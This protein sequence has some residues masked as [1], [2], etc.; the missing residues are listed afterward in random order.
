MT[1]VDENPLFDDDDIIENL[2]PLI[3][4]ITRGID[5]LVNPR[6]Q[7]VGYM[8]I[9]IGKNENGATSCVFGSNV[10]NRG[11]ANIMTTVADGIKDKR[12]GGDEPLGLGDEE[13]AGHA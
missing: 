7:R 13:P 3:E 10:K 4:I 12:D 11:A 9:L 1:G 2:D 8:V 6:E 5:N